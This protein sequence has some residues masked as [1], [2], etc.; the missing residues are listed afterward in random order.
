MAA[1]TA[2]TVF[3]TGLPASA[4]RGESRG[5]RV[6]GT[7]SAGADHAWQALPVVRVGDDHGG[8]TDATVVID[9][10]RLRQRYS[11]VG[12]SID[13]T[14]VSNLWKLTPAKR[15]EAIRLL[16]D[17]RRGAGLDRFRITIGSPD[18]IE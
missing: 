3:A 8:P 4:G 5:P 13:E 9:P 15:H 2:L 16:V 14:S 6:T 10:S 7:Y 18:L 12:F 17:P 11:G 1:A